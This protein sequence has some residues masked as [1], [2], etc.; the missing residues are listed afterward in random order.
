MALA[1]LALVRV[2]LRRLA[3]IASVD[4]L[5]L[6]LAGDW[7]L[8]LIASLDLPAL[9]SRLWLWIWHLLPQWGLL[10][11]TQASWCGSL[12]ALAFAQT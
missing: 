2:S 4:S 8:A 12:A 1:P 11:L 10:A 9:C 7:R 5:A 6:A 3:L